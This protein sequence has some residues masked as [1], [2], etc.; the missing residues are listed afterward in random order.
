LVT[1]QEVRNT[2]SSLTRAQTT[3]LGRE[4]TVLGT[5]SGKGRSLQT[6]TR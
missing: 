6:L 2:T 5:M 1:G 4:T 3:S